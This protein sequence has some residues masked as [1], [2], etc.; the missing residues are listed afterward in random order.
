[1]TSNSVLA[2][3]PHALDFEPWRRELITVWT[4]AVCACIRKHN[5]LQFI[6]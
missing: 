4:H 3:F 5:I 2:D 1:M 6:Y